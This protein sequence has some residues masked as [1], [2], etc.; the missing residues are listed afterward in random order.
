M[1]GKNLSINVWD[2]V[3]VK[4]LTNQKTVFERITTNESAELCLDQRAE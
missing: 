1:Y 4:N 3:E 2:N